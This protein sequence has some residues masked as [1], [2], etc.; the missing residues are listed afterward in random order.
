M[1]QRQKMGSQ[2]ASAG[3]GPSK[4]AADI[5]RERILAPTRSNNQA[6]MVN[7]PSSYTIAPRSTFDGTRGS[8]HRP[9][10]ANGMEAFRKM[11]Q[12]KKKGGA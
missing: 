10:G 9:L 4:S 1:A 11:T 5:E 12:K 2:Y 7:M 6:R 3:D 8:E